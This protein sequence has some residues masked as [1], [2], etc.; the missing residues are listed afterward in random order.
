MS[1]ASE[2]MNG[3][4]MSAGI[5]VMGIS[6]MAN[7]VVSTRLMKIARKTESIALESDACHLRTDIYTSVGSW[8]DW[9]SS[10]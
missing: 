10:G 3:V 1:P 7:Q 9:C 8:Q 4:L 2:P 5:A 6:A